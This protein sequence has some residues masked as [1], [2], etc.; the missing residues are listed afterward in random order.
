MTSTEDRM[1]ENRRVLAEVTDAHHATLAA[2]ADARKAVA[3]MKLTAALIA[4][5]VG[6]LAGAAVCFFSL[7]V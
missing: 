4:A 6:T 1:R 3:A 5:V 7:L 2:A